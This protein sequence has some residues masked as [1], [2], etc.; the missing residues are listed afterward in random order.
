MN[1]EDAR[2]AGAL[3]D[4]LEALT[5]AGTWAPQPRPRPGAMRPA[6]QPWLCDACTNLLGWY[7]KT[8]DELRIVGTMPIWIRPGAGGST[9]MVCPACGHRCVV[10]DDRTG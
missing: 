3:G 8:N 9:T 4:L 1:P 10:L 6:H 5:E 7:D 2:V